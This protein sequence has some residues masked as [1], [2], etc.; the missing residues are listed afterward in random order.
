MLRYL[1]VLWKVLFEFADYKPHPVGVV[2]VIRWLSQFP[3][4]C[5]L[6]LYMLLDHVVYFSERSTSD[7][8]VGLNTNI[9]SRLAQ[10]GVGLDH[11]IYMAIDSAGSSSHVMLNML[12]DRENLEKRGA[13]LIGSREIGVLSDVTTELG[14]GA[15]IYVDDFSGTGKQFV[16]NRKFAAPFVVGAFSEFFLAPVICEE[17]RDRIKETGVLPVAHLWH[18]RMERPLHR[19]CRVLATKCK[20]E[21]TSLCKQMND[22]AGLGFG[23]MATMV[24][25]YRNAPNTMPL[26]F[27]GSLGQKPYVGI[28]PRSDDL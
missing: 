19:D 26:V 10:D 17:A 25:F 1:R 5:R 11:V 13:R 23:N 20:D 8:L 9:L 27:R 7:K 18:S 28:F 2:S 14:Q 21:I 4:S 12:R 3:K 24:V 6:S 15:I 22:N 16:R